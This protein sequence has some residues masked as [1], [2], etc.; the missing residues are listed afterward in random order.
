MPVYEYEC[1]GCKKIFE[2]QQRIADAPV[3]T[4]PECGA[5][6]KK[7]I[8]M[9]SFQ[10]K[11]GGWYADGYSSA[12]KGSCAD[13]GSAPSCPAGAGGSCCQCPAAAS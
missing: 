3:S 6:V 8:S 11:G 5:D 7:L 12:D 1:S 10:L 4:C 9:S 2:I 13:T